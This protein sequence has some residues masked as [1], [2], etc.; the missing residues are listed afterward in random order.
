M[1]EMKRNDGSVKSELRAVTV[2]I[3]P[4]DYKL[5][6]E[7]AESRQVSLNTVISEVIAQ[8]GA[9]IRRR[10]VMA[11]VKDLQRRIREECGVGSD[12]VE[13]I[14]EAREERADQLDAASSKP[15]RE[16]EGGPK[17]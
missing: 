9:R 1:H 3:K 15:V 2:R 6:A 11:D 16:P 12:S 5:L 14:R 17:Q 8:Y 4:E 13:L 10:Q 7:Y